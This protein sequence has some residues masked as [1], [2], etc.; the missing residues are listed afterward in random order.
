MNVY[1]NQAL[2]KRLE[3]AEGRFNAEFINSRQKLFPQCGAEWAEIDGTYTLYDGVDSPLTQTFGLGLFENLSPTT[4]EKI[5]KFYYR[6]KAPIF[7]EVSPLTNPAH[8]EML[9]HRGYHP[10]EHTSIL[11]KP[12]LKENLV[13]TNEITTNQMQKGEEEIWASTSAKGWG[14]AEFIYPF[15][16]VAIRSKGVSAYFA[17]LNGKPIA[18]AMLF[19]HDKV[20]LLAGDSTIPEARNRG[21]QVA[22]IDARLRASID[23]GCTIAMLAASPGS[24]SQKNA[25]KNGFRLAYTRTKWKK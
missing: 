2:S 25:E 21:A 16:S 8:I 6:Y 20:A 4:L 10:V 11:Y 9:S 14:L 18:T 19:M 17:N 22:L 13:I 12:L 23:Q 1:S 3:A 15:A 24:Q 5:E 7:H